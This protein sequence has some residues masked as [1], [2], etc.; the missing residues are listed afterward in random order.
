MY[1]FSYKTE[2][3]IYGRWPCIILTVTGQEP[4]T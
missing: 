4:L 2:A 1:E 3:S